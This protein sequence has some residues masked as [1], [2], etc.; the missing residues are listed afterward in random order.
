[1]LPLRGITTVREIWVKCQLLF[2]S[3][4]GGG[5]GLWG[6]GEVN[7]FWNVHYVYIVKVE[8]KFLSNQ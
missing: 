1:M 5:G 6:W 8:G 7:E 4:R 3:E 2:S